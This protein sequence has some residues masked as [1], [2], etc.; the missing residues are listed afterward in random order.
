MSTIIITMNSA[1]ESQK[2]AFQLLHFVIMIVRSI[3]WSIN[4]NGIEWLGFLNF[5]AV[6]DDING[7]TMMNGGN[8]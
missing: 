5:L 7:Y 4:K 8:K 6:I 1:S 3:Y 2:S